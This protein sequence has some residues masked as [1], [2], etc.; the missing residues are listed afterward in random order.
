MSLRKI[1]TNNYSAQLM[2]HINTEN[3]MDKVNI[4]DLIT[5]HKKE[6]AKEKTETIIFVSLALFLIVVSGTIVSL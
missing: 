6:Q 5:R 1:S 4:N 2:S 3:T